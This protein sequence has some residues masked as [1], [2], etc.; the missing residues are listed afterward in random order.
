MAEWLALLP[1]LL[2]LLCMTALGWSTTRSGMIGA[3]T[4]AGLAIFAFD[5]GTDGIDLIGPVL[6][7]GSTAA[8]IHWLLLPL[9]P[10]W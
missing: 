2:L 7:A 5:Y 8:T 1:I 3:A 10:V 9:T 6:E 4:A